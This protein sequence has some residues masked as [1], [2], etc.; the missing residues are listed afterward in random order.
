MACRTCCGATHPTDQQWAAPRKSPAPVVCRGRE[1]LAIDPSL[2]FPREEDVD[3]RFPGNA[4]FMSCR[5]QAVEGAAADQGATG[6]TLETRKGTDAWSDAL[7]L[8]LP[9]TADDSKDYGLGPW[10]LCALKRGSTFP[11]SVLRVCV[12]LSVHALVSG[13]SYT[14]ILCSPGTPE[15]H[16]S[17]NGQTESSK[18]LTEMKE[19]FNLCVSCW[20][21]WI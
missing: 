9:P 11:D 20:W 14:H 3:S 6:V 4:A 10:F 15:L 5:H 19:F 17:S 8:F 12:S 7:E 13:T 2:E 16:S 21:P 18:R 1:C